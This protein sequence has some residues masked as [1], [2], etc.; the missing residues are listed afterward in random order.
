M[1]SVTLSEGVQT[2]GSQAFARNKLVSVN[3]PSSLNTIYTE[4]FITNDLA[5][6]V[7]PALSEIGPRSFANNKLFSVTFEDWVSEPEENADVF[8]GNPLLG[9]G[10]ISVS[11]EY[12]E[13]FEGHAGNFG[14]NPNSFVGR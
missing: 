13:Y 11:S 4:A 7:I 2:I 8:V 1:T 14:V 3:L 10:S 5:T 9:V 6:L 12:L